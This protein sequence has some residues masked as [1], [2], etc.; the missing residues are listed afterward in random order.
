MNIVQVYE[1]LTSC[2]PIN[3]QSLYKNTIFIAGTTYEAVVKAGNSKGTSLH[4]DTLKF[5]MGDKYITSAASQDGQDGHVGVVVAVILALV[6]VAA[7][8]AAAVWFVRTKKMLGVKN[9]NGIAFE[10]PSYLREVNMDHI[11]VNTESL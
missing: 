3:R 5:T 8:F 1:C 11:Q 9:S 2:S 7:I 6:V 10:N 4:S